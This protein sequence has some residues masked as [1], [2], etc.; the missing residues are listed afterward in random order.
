MEIKTKDFDEMAA[1]AL[2]KLKAEGPLL[3]SMGICGNLAAIVARQMGT[4]T[5]YYMQRG[6]AYVAEHSRGW[7]NHSGRYAYPVPPPLDAGGDAE[8]HFHGEADN[9]KN[10]WAGPYGEIRRD[11]LDYLIKKTEG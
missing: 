1:A 3:N 2:Q 9:G 10:L 7:G 5:V 4:S 8:D 6:T 11:L